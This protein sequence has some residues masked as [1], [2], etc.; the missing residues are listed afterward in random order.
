MKKRKS[1]Q[2]GLA[3]VLGLILSIQAPA[4]GIPALTAYAYTERTATVNASTL[5]VRSG[6]GT[7][8]S[9]VTQLAK[10][11][12][13]TVIGETTS[14]DGKLWYQ[15]RFSQNGTDQ[16]GYALGTYIRFA[17]SYTYDA[18]FE[19]HLTA[20]GFPESY[21]D[22][23][24]QL[25]AQYPSWV[26][27]AQ[28][29]SLDWNT[30]ISNEGVVGRNLVDKNSISSYKSIADGA[31]DWDT[32]SWP[33]F[34]GST[35]VAASEDIIRYYMDPRNFLDEVSVFQFLSQEYDA[36]I[37]TRE[38]LEGMLKGTFMEYQVPSASGS[39]GSDS[40]SGTQS[41]SVT[42]PGAADSGQTTSPVI[43]APSGGGSSSA[44]EQGTVTSGQDSVSLESP[45]ASISPH[46]VPLVT[47]SYGPGVVGVAPGQSADDTG[48]SSTGDAAASTSY[49]DII[50]N[51]AA[52]SGVNPY[53]LAAMLIQEQGREGKSG[54]ISGSYSGYEGYYNYFNVGA[55]QDGNMSAVQR[56]L[57]YAAQ[58]GNYGRPWNS[59]EKAIIGGA[60]FYGT[61]YVSAGQDTFYLK[62]YNVQGSNLYK[63]Q[64]MSNVNG[65]ESEASM[66]AEAYTQELRNTAL[67]FKIP[68]YTDM[69]ASPCA[70]PTGSGSPNNKL[71]D[72]GVDG[73]TLT[74]T[75]NK[76]QGAYDLIVDVS[77]SSLTVTANAID[78]TAVVSGTGTVQLQ[79]GST[80]ITVSVTAENG[81]IR[82]YIIHVVQQAN[83]QT[84]SQTAGSA[85]T[86]P[87]PEDTSDGSTVVGPGTESG[88]SAAPGGD[89]VIVISP[90][91]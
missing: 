44:T 1:W 9:Q 69:P 56:G 12:S 91:G 40:S 35:W 6:A 14:S 37:H 7:S 20:Q 78:S 60:L 52:Q 42:G 22:G 82:Q 26:F 43:V 25:H 66:F 33:G 50:M 36:S 8:Y 45:Q 24:R 51:A 10:G 71:R 62:K 39:S 81:S 83:G 18:D 85:A 49:T 87:S 19:A 74:P 46:N 32:S 15:I 55:Y 68:V 73:F 13:V 72:L 59:P 88:S 80:D 84:G 16:T 76:D 77:V 48:S 90:A 53:V 57:W 41:E 5:N 34:D 31:Y 21:K 17:V 2:K 27:M 61:N 28:H 63:H 65:A 30:V 23:L 86:N 3:A 38:G 64:Y 29:T 67:Q 54:L 79:G 58:E 4:G 47:S 89:N 11:A 75:Y 70:K